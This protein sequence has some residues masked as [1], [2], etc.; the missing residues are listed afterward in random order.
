VINENFVYLGLAIGSIGG[1]IYLIY[2]LQ[3]KVRPNRVTWFLWGLAPLIAFAAEVKQGIGP[4]ALFT[5]INGFFPLLIFIA[6]FLNKKSYWEISR[7]DKICGV[8][9]LGGLILWQL[10]GVGNIAILF[11]IFADGMAA[12]PT[13][14]KSYR[15]PE[16]ENA[17][18]YL[19]A[20]VG[21]IITLLTIKQWNF[22]TYGFPIYIFI[23]CSILTILIQFKIG[24]K[25]AK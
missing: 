17:F 16:S 6:S 11:S 20:A 2:T 21:G 3:G 7:F 15:H 24:K 13:I 12:L 25:L 9:A 8:I 22:A 4:I 23:A 18:A 5:F 14:I 10:T 19:T 1:I